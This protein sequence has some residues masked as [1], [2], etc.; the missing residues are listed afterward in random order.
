[1]MQRGCVLGLTGKASDAVQTITSGIAAFRSTGSTLDI[2]VYLSYPVHER[3][4]RNVI[5]PT[6]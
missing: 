5:Y 2:S 3:E 6:L 4:P 1:M